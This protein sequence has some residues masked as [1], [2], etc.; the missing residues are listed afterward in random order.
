MENKEKTRRLNLV[1]V[2]DFLLKQLNER[3]RNILLKRYGLKTSKKHTLEQIGK[4]Y[5]ITRERVRQIEKNSI[6]KLKSLD[7]ATRQKSRFD[8]V[9][10]LITN[11][12]ADNG[13]V[14]E[15]NHLV[16]K[17]QKMH[18]KINEE[19]LGRIILFIMHHLID[20][21]HHLK[22]SEKRHTSWKLH[23]VN[24]GIVEGVVDTIID[25]ISDHNEPLTDKELIA[26][27][28]ESPFFVANSEQ[29]MDLCDLNKD[30]ELT[31]HEIFLSYLRITKKV[32]KNIFEK[33]GLTSWKNVQPKK[34]NDKAYLVLKKHG[35]PLHFSEITNLINK[36]GFDNK[37][38]CP[39][40][41]HNELILNDQ[42]VLVGRGIYALK[43]W[44]YKEGTVVD[45]IYNILEK[46]G[47]P[48]KKDEIVDE[49]L[50]TRMV[51]KSTIYLS[52][53]NKTKFK[54][55]GLHEYTIKQ[56]V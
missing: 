17:I 14:I 2:I 6:N 42:Y 10:E 7:G 29:I 11:L 51:K 26:Q 4:S 30:G 25:L 23:H 39:A 15:E 31:L 24:E 47:G 46:A 38:A 52:L 44:G 54:K 37:V 50:K 28:E 13:G 43:E 22:A 19:I 36:A 34:I 45:V 8:E 27:F 18:Q 41:V 40:T 33:W 9:N 48:M 49:V 32:R 21:V 55:V 56:E 53:L 35:K 1:K 20:E 12:I 5:S 16:E 3:E